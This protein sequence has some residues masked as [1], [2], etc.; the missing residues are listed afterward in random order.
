MAA[1]RPA[2]AGEVAALSATLAQAFLADAVMNWLLPQRTR[3]LARR[4]LF[5]L[6][7]QTDEL[8]QNGL[9]FTTDDGRGG[10]VGGCVVLPPERWQM[11][12]TVDGRTA[13]RWLRA[14]G[15]EL[16]HATASGRRCRSITPPSRTTTS[17]ASGSGPACKGRALA[18]Q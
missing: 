18:A 13:A 2:D 8:P 15:M 14:F 10:L 5:R 7:L 9:V 16:P 12:N 11:P 6:E 3:R 1:V 4:E 17:A